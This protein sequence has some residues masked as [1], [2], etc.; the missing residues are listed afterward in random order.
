MPPEFEISEKACIPSKLK[1]TVIIYV[2]IKGKLFWL[3]ELLA[4]IFQLNSLCDVA[5][6]LNLLKSHIMG[7]IIMTYSYKIHI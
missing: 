3:S 5:F 7:I 6:G 4:Q 1:F 2:T